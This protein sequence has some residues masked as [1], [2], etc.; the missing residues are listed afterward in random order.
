MVRYAVPG[1]PAAPLI[2]RLV[3]KRDV[4]RIFGFRMRA[5]LDHFETRDAPRQPIH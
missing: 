1:G 2:H 5:L 4:D 3:V